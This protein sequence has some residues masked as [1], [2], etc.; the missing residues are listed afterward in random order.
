VRSTDP[1]EELNAWLLDQCLAHGGAQASARSIQYQLTIAKLPL[2]KDLVE[3]DF[4]G[5]PIT[6]K[7]VREL[8]TGGFLAEQRNAVLAAEPAPANRILPWIMTIQRRRPGL[9]LIPHSD[10]KRIGVS[11]WAA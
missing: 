11:S 6:E 8:A 10:S 1:G 7:L 4:A 3:F 5:T 2:A 9:D